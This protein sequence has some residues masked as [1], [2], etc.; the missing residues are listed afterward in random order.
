MEIHPRH[1]MLDAF[2]EIVCLCVA[3]ADQAAKITKEA[4]TKTDDAE[5]TVQGECGAGI[6]NTVHDG[7]YCRFF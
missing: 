1:N 6:S 2:I 3:E 5:E 4:R 7:S